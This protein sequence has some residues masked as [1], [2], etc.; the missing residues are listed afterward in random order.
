MIVTAVFDALFPPRCAA[1]RELLPSSDRA[2]RLGDLC[3]A[4]DATL[5]PLNSTCRRC[6]LPGPMDDSCAS[7]RA[8]PPVFDSAHAV[9]LYGAAIAQVLHRYKYE[10]QSHLARSL[11]ESVARLKLPKVDLVLPVPL[12][13]SRRRSRTYDQ[14]LYLAQRVAWLRALPCDA[15]TLVRQR[16]TARQVGQHRIERQRNVDDAFATRGSLPG[17]TVLLVDDVVTTGATAS[18]CARVLKSAGVRAVHVASVARAA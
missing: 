15:H 13:P 8:D 17:A 12:H 11:G 18:A 4:C 10:D 1:C 6:G 9:Y 16:A 3:P 5:E 2:S 14:A 7:C